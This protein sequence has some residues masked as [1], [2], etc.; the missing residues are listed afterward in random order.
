MY[1]DA[2]FNNTQSSKPVTRSGGGEIASN[3]ETNG[4]REI[5]D[6]HKAGFVG[7]DRRFIDLESSVSGLFQDRFRA[8][9]E[10][11]VRGKLIKH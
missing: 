8:S 5:M 1:D 9:N 4:N 10:G 11:R 2:G 6:S 3:R 7:F